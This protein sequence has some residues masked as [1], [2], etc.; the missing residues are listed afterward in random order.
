MKSPSL[1]V[2]FE[3]YLF[4]QK[5][6]FRQ[7]NERPNATWTDKR[8]DRLRKSFDYLTQGKHGMYMIGGS[9]GGCNGS[10]IRAWEEGRWTN[11]SVDDMKRILDEAGLPWK[12]GPEIEHLYA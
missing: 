10:P 1:E 9:L 4:L 12:D 2:P 5:E 6:C 7:R 3:S 11:W 8:T